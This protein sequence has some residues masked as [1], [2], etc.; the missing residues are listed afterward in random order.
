MYS[1]KLSTS[2]DERP[3]SSNNFDVNCVKRIAGEIQLSI[4]HLSKQVSLFIF[5]DRSFATKLSNV[6]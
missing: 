1:R 2:S 4:V 3:A 5:K 6:I